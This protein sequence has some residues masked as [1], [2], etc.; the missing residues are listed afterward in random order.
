MLLRI[1]KIIITFFVTIYT[2]PLATWLLQRWWYGESQVLVGFMNAIGVWWFLPLIALF[3]LALLFRARE[4]LLI[5]CFLFIPAIYF[6]G[7]EFVPRFSPTV[8]EDATRVKVLSFNM[9]T[10]NTQYDQIIELIDTHRPDIV[11]IQELSIDASLAINAELSAIYPHQQ[12]H[13]W[14]DPRGM[15]IWSQHPISEGPW[16][17]INYWERWLHSAIVEIEGKQLFL[18]NVHLWPTGTLDQ[19]QFAEALRIH[20]TQVAELHTIIAAEAKPTLL[21]GDFNASPTNETYALLDQELDDTW[22]QVGF[23]PGFTF[24]ST[25][26]SSSWLPRLLRID[27]M[28]NQGS[29]KP[30]SL[31]VLPDSVGSDHFPLLGEFVLE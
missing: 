30:I 24:P 17:T 5:L 16:H 29:V 6:F 4:A 20:E 10:S 25:S 8:A 21:V 14:N 15:G 1:C 7:A 27:Y 9:L 23:G 22:R 12:L 13:P 28:W 2:I 31:E 18:L 3:P 26:I 11:A 19:K